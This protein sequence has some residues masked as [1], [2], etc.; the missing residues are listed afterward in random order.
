MLLFFICLEGEVDVD[1]NK[2]RIFLELSEYFVILNV[3]FVKVVI[4]DFDIFLIFKMVF[5]KKVEDC[6]GGSI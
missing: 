2:V 5:E 1:I 6:I 4:I 3:N